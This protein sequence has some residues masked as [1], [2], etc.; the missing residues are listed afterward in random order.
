MKLLQCFKLP[1][2][3][4]HSFELDEPESTLLHGKIIKQK[5]FL[6]ELYVEHYQ[7]FQSSISDINEK[8]CVELGSGGGFI[9]EIIPSIITSDVLKLPNV[10]M[11]FSAL[12]MPFND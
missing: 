10:D 8:I 9:K 6:K 11:N 4:N 1:E 2:V 7:L 12:D 3:R 5:R